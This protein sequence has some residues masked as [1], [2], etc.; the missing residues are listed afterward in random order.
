MRERVSLVVVVVL[1]ID[2][3]SNESNS[4]TGIIGSPCRND[5]TS[6]STGYIIDVFSS[7]ITPGQTRWNKELELTIII[8]ASKQHLLSSQPVTNLSFIKVQKLHYVFTL[9]S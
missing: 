5:S 4:I 8:L 6:L 7:Q 2:S 9:L 1:R 3:T